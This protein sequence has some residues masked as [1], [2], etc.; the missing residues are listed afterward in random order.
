ML[1]LSAIALELKTL[2]WTVHCHVL[3]RKTNIVANDKFTNFHLSN[4]DENN[5]TNMEQPCN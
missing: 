4:M 2:E 5:S 3:N 1:Q